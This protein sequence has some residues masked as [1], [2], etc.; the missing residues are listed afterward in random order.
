MIP[1]EILKKV[2]QIEIRT[3]REVTDV[4]GGQYHSVFKGRGME[5][6]EVREYLP[7]DEV[8]AIDW[9]V[10]ARF[11]HPFIKKFKEEREL[12]VM[13]VVDVSA[14]GQFGSGQQ[15]KNELAAELAAVLAFSAIRNNDKVGV[16]LFSDRI[17]KYIAPDK[18]R[19]HVL[20]VVREILAF[21]PTGRGTNIELA[22][23][24]LNHV[25]RRRAVTFLLSDFQV[26][27]DFSRKLRI[28]GKRHDV[29]ALNL[30]DPR[31]ESLPAVGLVEL[32]D[33]ETGASA[34]VDTLDRQVRASFA[35]KALAHWEALREVFRL[36]AVDQVEIRTDTDYMRP[37]VKFFRMRGRRA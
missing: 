2:R 19:R 9:N 22:L 32:R 5:F 24:Y 36:A 37:L 33:A 20:C 31:E 18:G 11:G 23:D 4:L 8:R 10:T 6:E 29:V 1:R 28:A 13:L 7:G 30:R 26:A 14:S 16:I 17:E 35:A 21:Q 15:S 12:T 3:N 27:N 25:Q 34:L